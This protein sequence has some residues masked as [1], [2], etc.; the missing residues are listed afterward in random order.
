[1]S[2]L[3]EEIKAALREVLREEL[4]RALSLLQPRTDEDGYL[5]V[6]KAATLVEVHPDTIRAWVKDGRLVAHRA[7]RELR[8][9]RDQLRRF[10]EGGGPQKNRPTPE[11]KAAEILGRRRL[12]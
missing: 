3:A 1:M 8:I 12:G 9:R 7:G 2:A 4:P 10:L 6:Q 11:E 5:S